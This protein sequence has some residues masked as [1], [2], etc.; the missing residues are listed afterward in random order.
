MLL[1]SKSLNAGSLSA[2]MATIVM[3]RCCVGVLCLKRE[4]S[5]LKKYS[6][7]GRLRVGIPMVR[8]P[9]KTKKEHRGGTMSKHA[10]VHVLTSMHAL[11]LCLRAHYLTT[12]I[13]VCAR[14]RV[15]VC[16]RACVRAWVSV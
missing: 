16:V 11:S 6:P 13:S 10:S 7:L 1:T 5:V 9:G 8:Y 14:A 2:I 15:C 4:A 12:F 3:L